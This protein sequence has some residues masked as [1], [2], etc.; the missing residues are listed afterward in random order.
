MGSMSI[1]HWMI[2]VGV[3][4]LLFGKGKISGVMGDV[5]QGMKSFRK[6]LQEDMP[7]ETPPHNIQA[8]SE[9]STVAKS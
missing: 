3:V 1:V 9:T 5:A 8:A 7:V 2:V 4:V 6:G